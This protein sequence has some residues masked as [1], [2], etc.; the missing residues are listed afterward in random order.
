MMWI[1]E[2]IRLFNMKTSREHAKIVGK[3]GGAHPRGERGRV[4]KGACAS[5][6]TTLMTKLRDVVLWNLKSY[7]GFS[8]LTYLEQQF[9]WQMGYHDLWFS[10]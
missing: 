10:P 3:R 8:V 1:T 2:K 5:S 6:K 9:G 7:R 4:K